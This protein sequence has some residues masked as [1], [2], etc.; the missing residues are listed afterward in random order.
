MSLVPRVIYLKLVPFFCVL[1]LEQKCFYF[2]FSCYLFIFVHPTFFRIRKSTRPSIY[3]SLVCPTFLFYNS[4]HTKIFFFICYVTSST[5]N[6]LTT[7][8]KHKVHSVPPPLKINLIL[9]NMSWRGYG[10][11]AHFFCFILL[12]LLQLVLVLLTCT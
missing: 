6:F 11:C 1:Y 8:Y 2:I 10:L 9:R 5:L 4:C 12:V 3:P 7:T